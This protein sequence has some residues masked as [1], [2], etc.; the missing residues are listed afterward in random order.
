MRQTK[1]AGIK[2]VAL[3]RGIP[4]HAT[5]PSAST[6]RPR[7]GQVPAADA[8]EQA[9]VPEMVGVVRPHH[10]VDQDREEFAA[11][12]GDLTTEIDEGAAMNGKQR[13]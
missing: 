11:Y 12:A 4:A 8:R 7:R 3:R 10:V 6:R 9:E 13:V 5:L 2:S 1:P